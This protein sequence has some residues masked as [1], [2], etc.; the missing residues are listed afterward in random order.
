VR[1]LTLIVAGAVCAVACG[2]SS[3][4]PSAPTSSTLVITPGPE[5]GNA[6]VPHLAASRFL[7]FG[8]SITWGEDGRND[9]SDPLRFHTAVMVAYPY[10]QW[11]QL[12]LRSLYSAH[13][14]SVFNAGCR[15][16]AADS[17]IPAPDDCPGAGLIPVTR[18]DSFVSSGEYDAVLLMEG[19]NDLGIAS[20]IDGAIVA[21]G[22]MVEDAKAHHLH[23]FLATIPP[24]QQN[25][26]PSPA[27][28]NHPEADV[29]ALNV[30]I[31]SLAQSEGV[32]L[33]DVY[34][35]F[36]SPD[37]YDL[38]SLGLLSRDGL[39]PLES[40]YQLIASTFMGAL[41]RALELPPAVPTASK[42]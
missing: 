39:H 37:V 11:L 34:N 14:P 7:A 13:L 21:L 10:P 40:G 5:F 32:T 9:I 15:G 1:R 22:M 36:P 18:F 24:E 19:A 30:Q 6:S 41:Q 25:A 33:V 12:Q 17:Q 23:V 16:E 31:R 4:S 35:A 27:A 8:D 42:S 2:K 20:G 28:R 3:V 26:D 29:L 38:Y